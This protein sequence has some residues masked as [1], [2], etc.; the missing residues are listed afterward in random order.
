M[1][2]A[3]VSLFSLPWNEVTYHQQRGDLLPPKRSSNAA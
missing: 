2:V 1:Q 3:C